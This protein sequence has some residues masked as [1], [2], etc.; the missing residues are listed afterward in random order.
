[1]ENR[2]NP[3]SDQEKRMILNYISYEEL[4]ILAEYVHDGWWQE[5]INQGFHHPSLVHPEFDISK[6]TPLCKFCHLDLI[7]YSQLKE[8]IKELDIVTA[9]TVI[10][11]LLRLGFK[12]SK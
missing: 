6:P 9:K 7:P 12:L 4:G 3:I 2:P 10:A 5:K 8:E 11:G 1:M